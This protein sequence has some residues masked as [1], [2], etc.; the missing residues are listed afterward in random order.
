MKVAEIAFW[1][2]KKYYDACENL[3]GKVNSKNV[4][5][6]SYA[7]FV[8]E[9]VPKEIDFYSSNKK[10]KNSKAR[11]KEFKKYLHFVKP[12]GLNLI[13]SKEAESAGL[14]AVCEYLNQLGFTCFI[15]S[16]FRE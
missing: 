15:D 9:N 1:A 5:F 16:H 6:D 12:E 11:V 13:E 8:L 2:N 10:F 4:D 7:Y 3:K 14:K